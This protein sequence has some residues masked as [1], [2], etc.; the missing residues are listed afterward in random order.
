MGYIITA[1]IDTADHMNMCGDITKVDARVL[2]QH[3]GYITFDVRWDFD[4]DE[5][6]KLTKNLCTT[7]VDAGFVAFMIG[8]SY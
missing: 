4:T 8:H 2:S 6:K 7:L 5:Q 3:D 1:E